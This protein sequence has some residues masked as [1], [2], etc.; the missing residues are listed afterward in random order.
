MCVALNRSCLPLVFAHVFSVSVSGGDVYTELEMCA[1]C[2]PYVRAR[3][4]RAKSKTQRR[5]RETYE[6]EYRTDYSIHRW[7]IPPQNTHATSTMCNVIY[8]TGLRGVGDLWRPP[9]AAPRDSRH[10][11]AAGVTFHSNRAASNLAALP[12]Y[13]P[14]ARR[15]G[16]R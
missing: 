15:P 6:L 4:G 1:R 2:A 9:D 16:S 13:W 12:T 11:H 5:G 14:G 8:V 7:E 10:K 3:P